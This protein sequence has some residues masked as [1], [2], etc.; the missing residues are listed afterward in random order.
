MKLQ[1]V[2]DLH[3]DAHNFPDKIID[4]L[5]TPYTDVLVVAGDIITNG[6]DN[7]NSPVKLLKKLAAKFITHEI[8]YVPGNHDFY[9]TSIEAGLKQ[10]RAPIAN[11]VHV[12]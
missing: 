5:Y 1:I 3:L 6:F 2:S 11:N 4:D 8:L 10:L 9:G 7:N 12:L